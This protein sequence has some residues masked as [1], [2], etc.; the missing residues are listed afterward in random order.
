MC[1]PGRY[2]SLTDPIRSDPIRIDL[3]SPRRKADAL[4]FAILASCASW[5]RR[6]KKTDA[7]NF[8]G[9]PLMTIVQRLAGESARNAGDAALRAKYGRGSPPVRTR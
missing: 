3:M 7:R 9:H 2:A 6:I 5:T 4:N 1:P 8:P